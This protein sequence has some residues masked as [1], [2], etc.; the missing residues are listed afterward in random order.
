MKTVTKNFAVLTAVALTGASFS[1]RANAFLVEQFIANKVAPK[2]VPPPNPTTILVPPVVPPV[3]MDQF[4]KANPKVAP[5]NLAKDTSNAISKGI[6]NLIKGIDNTMKRNG[7]ELAMF[8]RADAC[9]KTLC[10]SEVYRDQQIKKARAEAAQQVEE[11]LKSS[12]AQ[13]EKEIRDK[14][15][16]GLKERRKNLVENLAKGKELSTEYEKGTQMLQAYLGVLESEVVLREN[17][18]ALKRPI[19]RPKNHAPELAQQMS[20]II[21]NPTV[22]AMEQMNY[23]IAVRAKQ[24]GVSI[25]ELQFEIIRSISDKDLRTAIVQ[26]SAGLKNKIGLQSQHTVL[27]LEMQSQYE[28]ID[29]AIKKIEGLGK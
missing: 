2:V 20:V 27:M 24:L 1:Q 9:L 5:E 13:M 22:E 11:A 6:D 21:N 17:F 26:V 4:L 7:K 15:T 23:Q 3:I 12:R 8:G 28:A 19:A 25:E 18:L 10:L 14:N 29:A 16:T